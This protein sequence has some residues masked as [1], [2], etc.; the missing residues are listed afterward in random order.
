MIYTNYCVD[1][2]LIKPKIERESMAHGPNI[3]I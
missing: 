2:H 1:S 3:V